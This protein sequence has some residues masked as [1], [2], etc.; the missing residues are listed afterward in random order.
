ML[1]FADANLLNFNE[2]QKE[3]PAAELYTNSGMISWALFLTA[4][5]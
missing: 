2:K 5:T 3:L 1:F 4:S